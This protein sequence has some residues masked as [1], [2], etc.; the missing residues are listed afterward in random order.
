MVIMV[1]DGSGWLRV[2]VVVNGSGFFLNLGGGG[3]MIVV[4]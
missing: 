3:F 4:V 1:G 2:W